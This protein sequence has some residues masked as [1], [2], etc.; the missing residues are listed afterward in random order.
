[1]PLIG[2]QS[3][4]YYYLISL[5]GWANTQSQIHRIIGGVWE[6]IGTL[7]STPALLKCDSYIDLWASWSKRYIQAGTGPIP[8]QSMFM[9]TELPDEL[10]VMSYSISNGFEATGDWII[11]EDIGFN[12][13]L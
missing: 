10:T 13:G 11:D 1:M 7:Y 4:D 12:V 9:N 3:V 2:V 8:G 6:P 5:G